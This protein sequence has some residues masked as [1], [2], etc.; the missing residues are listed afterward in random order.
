MNDKNP[1]LLCIG[2]VM[3]DVFAECDIPLFAKF[4]LPRP[5][6]HVDPERLKRILSALSNYTA[7]SGGGAANAAKIAALLETK[8][9]FRGFTGSDEY[10][11][12]FE[13]ELTEAGVELHLTKRESPTGVCLYLKAKSITGT[14]KRIVSAPGAS[15]ELTDS[16]ISDDDLK[17][18][19]LILVDGF[20]LGREDG[21]VQNI[22]E[23]ISQLGITAA[24]DIS[25]EHIAR[26]YAE[27]ILGFIKKYPLILF[28]NETEAYAFYSTLNPQGYREDHSGQ[29]FLL[30]G[31]RIKEQHL[32]SIFTYLQ[33]R[34]KDSPGTKKTCPVIIVKRG[35]EGAMCSVNGAVHQIKTSAVQALNTTGAGDAFCAAFLCAW[36]RGKSAEDSAAIGNKAA[37]II[38]K[39][40]GTKTNKEQFTWLAL[41]LRY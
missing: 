25:S 18:A 17:R 12:L 6:Q 19:R 41:A 2:N 38:L 21:F 37:Q 34:L 7:V 5:V 36:L 32:R 31:H 29:L 3:V 10:A 39:V 1:D 30:G 9:C 14:E 8:V 16:D 4:E 27:N 35:S 20:I 23:R 22:L 13:K 24:L 33:S 40:D 11:S 15:L 28:M 26:K